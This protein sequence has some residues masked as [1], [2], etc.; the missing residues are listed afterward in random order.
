MTNPASSVQRRRLRT[1]L[2]DIRGVSGLTQEQV[3]AAMEWSV[4]KIIRIETGLVGI[5][6]NDLRALLALYEI[7]DEAQVGEML[8]LARAGRRRT[9]LAAYR[10]LLSPGFKLFVELEADASIIKQFHPSIIPGLL[11]IPEYATACITA[12]FAAADPTVD[13][14]TMVE[15]RSR[16]QREIFDQEEPPSLTFVL[17]EAALRRTV[18]GRDVMRK[19]LSRLVELASGPHVTVAI[20][21]FSHGAHAGFAGPYIIAEFPD[22]E[23]QPLLYRKGPF[24]EQVVRD[25]PDI[26]GLYSKTFDHLVAHALDESASI[27]FIRRVAEE[28]A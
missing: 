1:Q 28:L 16:R 6:V 22:N 23:S 26:I 9:W 25:K 5:S 21:P 4:S 20:I 11:Q 2:R 18:G 7:S 3:A 19:Q 14:S 10:H 17:D 24:T 13:I 8:D 27:D 15:I 12:G